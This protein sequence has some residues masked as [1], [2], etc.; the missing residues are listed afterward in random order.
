M[1]IPEIIGFSFL[2]VIVATVLVILS[3]F[4][5]E[6]IHG[7]GLGT[8]GIETKPYRSK[9]GKIRTARKSRQ[10]HIV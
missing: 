6:L 9:S 8:K 2:F 5:A 3:W 1:S 7:K 4:M 10:N